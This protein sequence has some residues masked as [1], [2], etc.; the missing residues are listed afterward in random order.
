MAS[1]KEVAKHAGVA[2]ST[3]SK[4][5]NNYP[6]VSEETKEKVKAAI[7]EL[8]YVPNAVA[9]AL[10]S[11]KSGR[12]AIIL[13]LYNSTQPVDEVNMQYL[14]G[15]LNCASELGLDVVTLFFSSLEN[16]TVEE[17]MNY[18]KSQSIS[19]FIICGMGYD[20]EQFQGL[21]AASSLRWFPLILPY[22]MPAHP[23][24][25]LINI[26]HSMRWQKRPWRWIGD[27]IKS[28]F[29]Y[30]VCRKAM[31]QLPEWRPSSNLQKIMIWS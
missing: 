31:W 1:I 23:T 7:D 30:R 13:R 21:V 16:K 8:G 2:I 28:F 29:I 12:I 18:L 17:M 11:K 19:G 3:V 25:R 26:K 15:T 9:A 20:E 27:L 14:Y 6:N 22:S 4:V 24:C 5:L 10:S